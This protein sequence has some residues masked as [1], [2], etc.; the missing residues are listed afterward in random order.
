M[1]FA[2]T[3]TQKPTFLH[4]VITGANSAE[5]VRNYLRQCQRECKARKC[6]RVLIEERLEG[7]RPGIVDVYRIVSE[8]TVRALGQAEAIAYVGVNSEATP[9]ADFGYPIR[10]FPAK[11]EQ[12]AGQVIPSVR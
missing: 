5:S 7:P 2:V 11:L 4:A 12:L 10:P 9:M 3:F 8:G 1:G 6:S